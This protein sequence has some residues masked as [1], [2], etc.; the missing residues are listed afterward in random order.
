MQKIFANDTKVAHWERAKIG[1]RNGKSKAY[2]LGV[3]SGTACFADASVWG[4]VVS[5][6]SLVEKSRSARAWGMG[7]SFYVGP[8]SDSSGLVGFSAGM[9]DGNY[10]VWLGRN[11]SNVAVAVTI[12]FEILNEEKWNSHS[13]AVSSPGEVQMP[14]FAKLGLQLEILSRW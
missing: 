11:D 12:D 14:Q 4:Q 9:G 10:T 1:T 6:P 8:S 3:D 13:F 5:D 7:E 2:S